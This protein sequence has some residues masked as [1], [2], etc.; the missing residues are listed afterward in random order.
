LAGES[1]SFYLK[2]LSQ[3]APA[4]VAAKS[5][6][7]SRYSLVAPGNKVQLTLMGSRLRAFQWS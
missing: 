5:P 1:D 7:F 4:H 2:F 3:P 6:I